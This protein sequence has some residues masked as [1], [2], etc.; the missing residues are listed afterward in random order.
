MVTMKNTARW[1]IDIIEQKGLEFFESQLNNQL[2]EAVKYAYLLGGK[3]IRPLLIAQTYQSLTACSINDL[4]SNQPL[5]NAMLAIEMIHCY[6]L[7]HDDLPAMDNDDLR[8]GKPSCHKAFDE[9]TAI[10]AGDILQSFAFELVAENP[11]VSKILA[12][13]S[14]DMC[15]G[16]MLDLISEDKQISLDELETIHKLKTGAL[17]KACVL[18]GYELSGVKSDEICKLLQSYAKHLGLAFQVQD[19]IL[20][21]I[22]TPEKLGKKVQ[23][24]EGLAKSTYPKLLGLK[25]SQQKLQDLYQ[26]SIDS[27]EQIENMS[28][29][30]LQSLKEIADFV[31]KRDC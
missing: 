2:T 11:N 16:Q 21:V 27:L 6:S 29:L 12:K 23:A 15:Y 4:Q 17:I 28:D 31:I 10:L 9:R 30:N 5:Q 26:K 18:M 22:G 3:R 8:R 19:D 25:Q 14:K 13:A 20:D 7:I 24:D 1:C